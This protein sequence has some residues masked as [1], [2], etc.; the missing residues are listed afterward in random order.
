MRICVL[1]PRLRVAAEFSQFQSVTD[2]DDVVVA[3]RALTAG[4]LSEKPY[5]L[6][7]AGRLN[8]KKTAVLTLV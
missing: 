7:S 3:I 4:G 6:S 1:R 8:V 2:A 5:S